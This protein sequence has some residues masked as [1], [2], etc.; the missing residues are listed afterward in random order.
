MFEIPYDQIERIRKMESTYDTALVLLEKAESDPGVLQELQNVIEPLREYYDGLYWMSD[1]EEDE[2]GRLPADLKRGVLSEDGLYDL[3]ERY[4]ELLWETILDPDG[5]AQYESL[6]EDLEDYIL[7]NLEDRPEAATDRPVLKCAL[8]SARIR[9]SGPLEE[10]DIAEEGIFAAPLWDAEDA[11]PM[12]LAE[13]RSLDDAIRNL[14]KSFMELV[15]SFA[16]ARGLTDVE[17]QKRAHLDR[18]AF[19]KLK[20]GT[21]KNPSKATALALAV[22]LELNLDDTRDLLSRAGLALS[23]C[24]KQDLI[25]QYF[26]EK[27]AY[28]LNMINI[29]LYDHGEQPIGG[30][31][32]EMSPDK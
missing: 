2:A 17:V 5:Q 22:A 10:A 26:I 24:S 13:P 32:F 6:C 14:D 7:E 9:P 1:F 16:D 15:F 19:S 30:G 3:L 29:A 11:A 23:P 31:L 25:V 20:C 27:E 8:R 12:M 4:S 21:T 28:D 18:K